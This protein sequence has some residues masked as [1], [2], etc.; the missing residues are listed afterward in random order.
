VILSPCFSQ[1]AR[2]NCT[3][4]TGP[5]GVTVLCDGPTSGPFNPSSGTTVDYTF[6]DTFQAL[7]SPSPF[8]TNVNAPAGTRRV[9]AEFVPGASVVTDLA[10]DHL[11]QSGGVEAFSLGAYA[12][13]DGELLFADG[14]VA[15]TYGTIDST[16]HIGFIDE[17]TTGSSDAVGAGVMLGVGAV[18]RAGA[19]MLEPRIGLDYDRND[20]RDFTERGGATNL[21]IAGEDHDVFRSNIG[22]RMHTITELPSGASFMPEVSMAWSRALD[23]SAVDLPQRGQCILPHRARSRAEMRC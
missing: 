12:R 19:M 18:I 16:R 2:A 3:Q 10:L 13:R 5:P 20:Q 17:K 7:A 15:A 11:P 8:T 21:H 23:D 22:V 14:G 9:G 4:L 6:A 1:S